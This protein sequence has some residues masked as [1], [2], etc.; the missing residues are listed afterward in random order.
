MVVTSFAQREQ[1]RALEDERRIF[2]ELIWYVI[3]NNRALCDG[4]GAT[5]QPENPFRPK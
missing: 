5:P 4:N 1:T 2:D 3:E